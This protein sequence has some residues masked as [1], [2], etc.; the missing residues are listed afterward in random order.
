MRA[1]HAK[2]GAGFRRIF[3]SSCFKTHKHTVLYQTRISNVSKRQPK[4]RY[5]TERKLYTCPMRKLFYKNK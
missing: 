5:S 4:G 2:R 1:K 3:L